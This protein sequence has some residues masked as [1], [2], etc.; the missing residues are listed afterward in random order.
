MYH[1]RE[2]ISECGTLQETLLGYSEQG[3]VTLDITYVLNVTQQLKEKKAVTKTIRQCL[4]YNC[5][6]Q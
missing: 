5:C 3:G 4:W 2:V 1:S 6:L